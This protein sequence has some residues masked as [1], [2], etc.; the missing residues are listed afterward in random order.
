MDAGL[1]TGADDNNVEVLC[2]HFREFVLTASDN[3]VQRCNSQR[4]CEEYGFNDRK[5]NRQ[6]DRVLRCKLKIELFCVNKLA[7]VSFLH[8]T[9]A[10]DLSIIPHY[11]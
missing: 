10:K 1:H 5:D 2:A 4:P 8:H 3:N 9:V 11:C 7:D 6:C